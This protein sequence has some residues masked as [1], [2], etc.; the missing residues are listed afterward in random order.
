[1]P[2]GQVNAIFGMDS[3]LYYF[4][5]WKGDLMFYQGSWANQSGSFNGTKIKRIPYIEQSSYVEVYPQSMA[6]YLGLLYFGLGAN[7]NSVT[8]PQGVYS[9]GAL[10]PDYPKSLSFEHIISTGNKGTT[11]DIGIVYPVGEK[12]LTSWKDGINYGVDVVDP[13]AGKYHTSGQLQTNILDGQMIYKNDLL[14]KVRADFLKLNTGEGLVVGYKKDREANF[15]VSNSI[16]DPYLKS[17]SNTLS[18][19]RHTEA[20]LLVQMTGNG[21]STPTLL[22]L[23]G[24][25][26]NLDSELQF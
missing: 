24:A 10:Y 2:E 5:G 14:L 6:N 9:W 15:E 21:S 18:N 4:A 22:A 12:L 13:T 1:V 11:V 19:G 26:D 20:Q 17:A 16:I 23:A 25:F 3:D 8:L 7:S